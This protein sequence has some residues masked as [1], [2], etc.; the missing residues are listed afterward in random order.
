L[1]LWHAPLLW[2]LLLALVLPPLLPVLLLLLQ[3]GCCST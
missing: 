1:L 2:L 3:V